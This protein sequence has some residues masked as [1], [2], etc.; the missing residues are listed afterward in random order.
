MDKSKRMNYFEHLKN[1]WREGFKLLLLSLFHFLH[2]VIR[3]EK[4]SH[5]YWGDRI[6][7]IGLED[8]N[9]LQAKNYKNDALFRAACEVV[10]EVLDR[11][12]EYN[13]IT[14]EEHNRRLTMLWR[15]KNHY[16]PFKENSVW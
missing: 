14:L 7:P 1:N 16:D 8:F 3:T 4:T 2:G 13:L 6:K 9:K 15:K 12:L 10:E 11:Q 5:K